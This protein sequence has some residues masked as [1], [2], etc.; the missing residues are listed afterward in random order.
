MNKPFELVAFLI[1]ASS[2]V[3]DPSLA[4]DWPVYRG[5][6]MA[7][8]AV[9]TAL[10]G[11]P[12]VLWKHSL[13]ESGYEGTAVIA[14]GVVYVGDNDGMLYA[15]QLSDGT[16]VWHQKF[17][18]SG[19]IAGPTFHDGRIYIGDFNGIIR[20]VDAKNG[21]LIWEYEAQGESYA[22]PN[23]V[24][25]HVLATTE[26]GELVALDL[27]SGE[28]QW[29][30]QIEAPL[31]CWPTVVEGHVL[32]AG[33][34]ERV[35][36]I[37]IA[38]GKEV[39]GVDIDGPT[40]ST[41][42]VFDGKALFGTEQGSFYAIRVPA[43]E[44]AWRHQDPENINPIHTAAA[45]DSRAVVFGTQGKKFYAIHP[46]SGEMLW[47]FP[48]RSAVESSPVIVGDSVFLATKRGVIHRVDIATGKEL[49]KYEAGGNFQAAFAI[50]NNR[51]VIGNTDGTL[52]CF[53]SE[54]K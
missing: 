22:A 48:V 35:H 25:D 21:D 23:V 7:T 2:W 47:T 36:A 10:P 12:A 50:A 41:P 40:G 4:E 15:Y 24:G 14:E 43:M 33:C 28:L 38:S 44:I 8:G 19:F 27:E 6:Q 30:F 49:W 53:S 5:N 39:A 34:D 11:E 46:E 18:N 17:E 16:E 42:A 52:Y 9:Q 45:V 37:D 20:A 54:E 32:L 29:K 1:I 31:R 51:L 3:L 26:S 13:S